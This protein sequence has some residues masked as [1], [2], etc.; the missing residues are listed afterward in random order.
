ML[1]QEKWAQKLGDPFQN[2]K[3]SVF[4]DHPIFLK[5]DDINIAIFIF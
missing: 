3:S 1:P 5:T 4:S 2:A